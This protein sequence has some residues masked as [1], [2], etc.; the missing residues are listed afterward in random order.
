MVISSLLAQIGYDAFYIWGIDAIKFLWKLGE[1][2]GVRT[3]LL[4]VLNSRK[5]LGNKVLGICLKLSLT[6]KI[7]PQNHPRPKN[8]KK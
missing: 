4:G 2:V 8:S 7:V 5:L 1:G 6:K 3:K